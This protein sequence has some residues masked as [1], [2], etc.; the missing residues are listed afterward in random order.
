MT[1]T[2]HD[3]INEALAHT[4]EVN[5]APHE[6]WLPKSCKRIEM[7]RLLHSRM[8]DAGWLRMGAASRLHQRQRR[9]DE[10]LYQEI[11]KFLM[12]EYAKAEEM[13]A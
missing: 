4:I 9:K 2:D 3:M 10:K 11:R 8:A 6:P 12:E 1:D 7:I 13:A 5:G